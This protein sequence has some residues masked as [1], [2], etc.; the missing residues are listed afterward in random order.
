M[1]PRQ[2]ILP[3]VV[4][5]VLACG[6]L[7]C[8]SLSPSGAPLPGATPGAAP[9]TLGAGTSEVDAA[10]AP[11]ASTL[12]LPG[13][14]LDAGADADG[15]DGGA[16]YDFRRTLRL[17]DALWLPFLKDDFGSAHY[18]DVME[19]TL[20]R[21]L[22]GTPSSN[23]YATARGLLSDTASTRPGESYV[24]DQDGKGA[25]FTPPR[26]TVVRVRDFVPDS[27]R[28]ILGAR[29]DAVL[30]A[31]ATQTST[32][33]VW[34]ELCAERSRA[35]VAVEVSDAGHWTFGAS[36]EIDGAMDLLYLAASAARALEAD[37][38]VALRDEQLRAVFAMLAEQSATYVERGLQV[39][40]FAGGH[41]RALLDHL[42][43]SPDSAPHRAT[44]SAWLGAGWTRR[45]LGF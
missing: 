20:R 32:A 39:S 7:G 5:G 16:D 31:S 10:T 4:S 33:A 13:A 3:V 35:R 44:L 14:P 43:A 36:A 45:V 17:S 8:S 34:A 24:Y 23:A 29:F 42:R 26:T 12:P 11:N 30:P 40:D 28:T 6:A 15:G 38:A 9:G 1:Q 27:A 21:T 19:R 25:F 37:E 41:A 2:W 18:L 22:D